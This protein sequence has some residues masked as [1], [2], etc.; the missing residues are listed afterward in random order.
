MWLE[1][2][3][4]RPALDMW[5]EGPP[6]VLLHQVWVTERLRGRGLGTQLLLYAQR[7]WPRILLA[8]VPEPGLRFSVEAWYSRHGFLWTPAGRM[9]EWTSD[10]PLAGDHA[11]RGSDGSVMTSPKGEA[12]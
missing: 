3:P 7:R 12:K 1:W 8:P 9:M 10:Q 2:F 4:I 6:S 5:G 11:A